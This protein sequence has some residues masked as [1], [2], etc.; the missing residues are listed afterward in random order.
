MHLRQARGPTARLAIFGE[1]GARHA[2]F[3]CCA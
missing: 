3:A 1:T 2:P